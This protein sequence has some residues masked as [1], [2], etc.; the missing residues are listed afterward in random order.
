MNEVEAMVGLVQINKLDNS[1][2]IRER[3]YQIINSYLDSLKKF[4]FFQMK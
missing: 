4:I 1:L 3:N 2:K